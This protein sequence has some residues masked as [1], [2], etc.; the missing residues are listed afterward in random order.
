[1]KNLLR[2]ILLAVFSLLG[3]NNVLSQ[4]T[5][6]I[7]QD[8][9]SKVDSLALKNNS[10]AAINLLTELNNQAKAQGN[11]AMVIKSVL[12]RNL[13]QG[14]FNEENLPV[15][16][17]DLKQ[18]IK[19]AS[20]P[21]KSIL[22]SL[23]AEAYWSY[24]QRNSYLILGRTDMQGDNGDDIRTWSAKKIAE[25]T[26]KT[27]FA[28]LR[29][30]KLLQN[31]RTRSF[32]DILTGDSTTRYLRP[33][34][35]DLLAQRA[36]EAF[37]N[38]AIAS[39]IANQHFTDPDL[40]ANYKIFSAIKLMQKDSTD[41]STAGLIIFQDLLRF[42]DSDKYTAASAD[43]DLRRLKFVYQV[44]QAEDKRNQY[45]KS[46]QLLT[47]KIQS[48]E[49]YADLLY[50][51][52]VQ[53]Q[54]HF[55]DTEQDQSDLI[56][57]LK[58]AEH[59][60]QLYPESTGAENAR[61]L[62]T[63]IKSR[64]LTLEIRDFVLQ[65]Q[66]V[67]IIFNY[68][69]ISS[70]E[71]KLYKIPAYASSRDRFKFDF[72]EQKDYQ[73]FLKK[74][75]PVK[76]WAVSLPV[77][78]DYKE[79]SLYDH[80]D[81]LQ[82]G[83]Y[84][85][86]AFDKNDTSELKLINNYASFQVTGMTVLHRSLNGNSQQYTVFDNQNGQPLK[87]ITVHRKI[88]DY[89]NKSDK[90]HTAL[91]KTDT[92][93]SLLTT[94]IS[95]SSVML[96]IRGRDSVFMESS[97][98][99]ARTKY[100]TKSVILFTDRPI[101]RPGQTVF[102]KGLLI[103]DDDNNRKILI[104]ETLT[105]RFKDVNQQNIKEIQAKTNTYGTFQGSFI[106]PTGKLNG[107][108]EISTDFG[109]IQV[110][111]EEY[112][113]PSFEVIFSSSNQKYKMNDS[114]LV[115]GNALSFAGYPIVNA[116]VK[117]TVYKSSA[118]YGE[119]TDQLNQLTQISTGLTD[120]K[121]NG[122]FRLTFF[123]D[124]GSKERDSY[125][126]RVEITDI[127]GETQ[128]G[129]KVI[130]TGKK[131][132]L[133]NIDLPAR[134][135]IKTKPDTIPFSI[136]NLNGEPVNSRLKIEWLQLRYPGRLINQNFWETKPERYSLGKEEFVKTFPSEEYKNDGSPANWEIEKTVLS[137]Q[138]NALNGKGN[139][140]VI[141]N[142][143]LPGY[144][145]VL[146]TAINDTDTIKTEKITRI[147]SESAD[148]ILN[149]KEE[150]LIV[151]DSII[152]SSG[153]AVFRIAGA[154]GVGTAYYEV[155]YKDKIIRKVW[156]KTSPEQTIVK[157]APEPYFKDG[158]GVQFTMVQ[159]GVTY[160]TIREVK[161]AD[162]SKILDVRF[163]T[164]R[165]KLQPGEKESWKIKI[166]NKKGEK[167]MAEMVAS[168]YDASLNKLNEMD[169]ISLPEPITDYYQFYWNFNTN[170]LTS[171]HTFTFLDKPDPSYQF[172][173]HPYEQISLVTPSIYGNHEG[174]YPN[175]RSRLEI[176]ERKI[177]SVQAAKKL[178]VL[179]KGNT[180]Y[181]LVTDRN[182]YNVSGVIVTSG[183]FRTVTDMFGIYRISVKPNDM[184][185]F[186]YASYESI[187]IRVKNKKRSDVILHEPI[188]Y[189]L[190][191]QLYKGGGYRNKS[192]EV[193]AIKMPAAAAESADEVSKIPQT[194]TART[195]YTNLPAL[196]VLN[197]RTSSA[198]NSRMSSAI[199][200]GTSVI[201]PRTNFSETAFF[202][203]QL[204]TD[205]AG[206]INIEF[207]IPQSLTRYKMMGFAHTKTLETA[208]ITNE[209]VTQKQLAISVNAPRFLRE[210]D[211]IIL[212]AKVNNL[213]GKNLKVE[214][215]L[216]L[217]D[218]LTGK[219]INLLSK[220]A[221]AIQEFTL[222]DEGNEVLKWPLIIPSGI[223]AVTYKVLAQSGKYSDGEEMT[224]PVLPNSILVTQSMS[225]AV[226]GNTSKTFTMDKLLQSGNSATMRNQRISVEF[227]ANP[228]WYAIQALPY[229]M[230]YPYECAE[231][232]FS[233]FYANSFAKSIINSSAKIREVFKQWQTGNKE[234]LIADLEKNPALKSILS[235]E[236]PWVRE[237]VD[238]ADRKKRLA[239]L[240]DLNHMSYELKK[241]FDMLESMQNPNG[242][243]PWFTGMSEDRY[244]TQH[245]V[246]GM[247]QLKKLNLID[248]TQTDR[249]NKV[250]S[251]AIIYLDDKLIND[252][253]QETAGKGS[254]YLSMH[255]LYARS[256][257]SQPNNHP[258]YKKAL[259]WYL[260]KS[261]TQ[262]KVM[263][264][265][266]QGQAALIL[267]RSGNKTEALKIVAALKDRAQHNDE[268]G[269]YWSA[270]TKGRWW[271][272][273]PVE[274]QALLLEV[275]DE[276]TADKNA[277]EELK[278]W[279][280]KNKQT[281]DWATTKATAAACYALLNRGYNL[282]A[283]QTAPTVLIGGQ[284]LAQ[285]SKSQIVKEAGTGYQ[286]I[287]IPA[288]QVKPEMG[289]IEIRNNN[290]G[291]AW[292][293]F[294]WQY[295]EQSDKITPAETGVKIKKQLFLQ[296]TT[297]K[298]ILLSPLT[299][300]NVL[301]PG[302]LLKVRIEIYADRDMEYIHLKDMRSAGFEPV[303]VISSYKYQDGLEYYES[304]KDASDNFFISYLKKGVYVFE[305]ALRVNQAG[306]FSNGITTLQCMY[307]PEFST[308]SEGIRV[309]VQP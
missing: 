180:Y 261:A 231:Q 254:S 224:I 104:N 42:H 214:A 126:I 236:T 87:G 238:D 133:L 154:S 215:I 219:I 28:S 216:E 17:S 222:K 283:E 113:R 247:G 93:G 272:Q 223:G 187:R 33:T 108:M 83:N 169:W 167:Q 129:E 86:F 174:D 107:Q 256:Y 53:Y 199:N 124:K 178:A 92:N 290:K 75:K 151:Q 198:T 304:T 79:H 70:I 266:Q 23:L 190:E 302:D 230:E 120:T 191:H 185:T 47:P 197:S 203:P 269:M 27:T 16:I 184:L 9:F 25:E 109:N 67:P 262:W 274:T 40:F 81:S 31:T 186:K 165:N 301:K 8:K 202:Y 183:K 251:K 161:I 220:E 20:Q 85:L 115:S 121:M 141:Q 299:A 308:H 95:Q 173:E 103:S 164:F 117:Y 158:F 182:G 235:E 246:L 204:Q 232:T 56:K 84:L 210:G 89:N 275:F 276:V 13:F 248:E 52:A 77:T 192:P 123:A 90:R 288:A 114:I 155:L 36:I 26:V 253:K 206:E 68:K 38:P 24:Y 268:M 142:S 252:Y 188:I 96:F 72:N 279:L 291:I 15:I 54:N 209:L 71:L 48:T 176:T 116:K 305:Y 135:F 255:Y 245:I 303:N 122:N 150:W 49:I 229:L 260:K 213:S 205:S 2:F 99:A 160:N 98:S 306:N 159:N 51:Q 69:N 294:Y 35:Y 264:P 309:N 7:W 131:D 157:I 168:L 293:G 127:N 11:Q 292:G 73:S 10:K 181:G 61:D 37:S 195:D 111:V 284:T 297:A 149:L 140:D 177:L 259:S 193:M 156:L 296:N 281:N 194:T 105:V 162:S 273:S 250:L 278:I 289:K 88:L 55:S 139:L 74:Y 148:P 125:Q 80:V 152:T 22:Q 21:A 62:I 6:I 58:T 44:Y 145:K 166:S 138:I 100:F 66:P 3:I 221:K 30:V 78:A 5:T 34:L 208:L 280:L 217:K 137:S 146:L 249:F 94:E 143:L 298:G 237:S 65:N 91:F 171:N 163:M 45:L 263:E 179:E 270:N 39:D 1:M 32:T 60:V 234:A 29:E 239:A 244:I 136:V 287:N 267:N 189:L 282:L 243:F 50:E 147:F 134:I 201:N 76:T 212:T 102:Y 97:P 82:Y 175:Y 14:Y 41:F 277:V 130:N 46:L 170:E 257:I 265:Y 242:S 271:Y 295:F 285:L 59:A 132:I 64:S 196:S 286:Q 240:F 300:G 128:L 207:T 228:V 12:Y 118:S 101:Y 200:S 19:Q 119:Y 241:S 106:I 225:M 153:N 63:Q 112:K 144:Y 226:R 18:D 227:T 258:E 110:Q 211:T 307:A 43:A 233:R 4:T 57:A 218:A 172:K